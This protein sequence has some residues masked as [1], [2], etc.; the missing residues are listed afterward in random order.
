MEHSTS[1]RS[2]LTYEV[3]S[4]RAACL[5][6]SLRAFGYELPTALADIIDNSIY[7]GANSVWIHFHWAGEQSAITITDDG[8]G[9][10]EDALREAMRPGSRNPNDVRAE[11]D[12]GRFGLGLKTAS[13]SQCRRVS[14]RTR[15]RG[16]PIVNRCWDL[17]HI[18]KVDEW[19]LLRETSTIA[20]TLSSTLEELT[21]GTS[22]IWE[23]LDRLVGGTKLESDKDENHFLTRAEAVRDHLSMVFHRF[24]EGPRA[25]RLFINN[26]PIDPWDPFLSKDSA[27]QDSG[28][29]RPIEKLQCRGSLV[30]IEPYVLPHLSKLGPEAHKRASGPRGWNLHQG[31]YIYRNRRLLVSGDWLGIRGWRPEEHYKLARIRVDLPNSL[32]QEWGID[33]TKSKA[34]PP[35][36]LRD[37]L[38]RIGARTRLL[39]KQVYSHRGAKLNPIIHEKR[40]FLWEQTALHNQVFYR[41]N[42][43]HAL[44]KAV[45]DSAD[46]K[47]KLNALLRLIEETI[48]I[49]LITIT[50]RE[51]PDQTLGAFENAKDDDVSKVMQETY[52]ALVASGYKEREAYDRL[53]GM[54]PFPR[55]PAELLALAEKYRIKA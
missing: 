44:V 35:A 30:E 5:V 10:R 12:L 28:Q 16:C 18:A 50:D 54:E 7:A 15:Q 2:A 52:E 11:S 1:E 4:P 40:E 31:F 13:F 34:T 17:D 32:D 51:K 47:R 25:L 21:H 24:L 6:E 42:R 23:N 48:P 43:K 8:V 22:V 27:M 33:V 26:I 37:D 14:V 19:Q 45:L 46:N 38:Q 49:P 41:I 55:F 9:M 29:H 53:G 20:R 39:A 3:A 36:E